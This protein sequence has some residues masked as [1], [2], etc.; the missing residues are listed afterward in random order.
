[1]SK[2]SFFKPA[3]LSRVGARE[4]DRPSVRL[5]VWILDVNVEGSVW[6]GPVQLGRDS[7]EFHRLVHIE[8]GRE[9]VMVR[10]D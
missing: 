4:F 3:R 1:M 5:A 6:I 8:L 2:E 10:L 9:G 7:S